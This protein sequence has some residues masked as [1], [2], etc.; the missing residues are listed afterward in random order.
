MN[1]ILQNYTQKFI[2]LD[3]EAALRTTM[4]KVREQIVDIREEHPTIPPNSKLIPSCVMLRRC[5][6]CCQSDL[7][8]C[9]PTLIYSTKVKVKYTKKFLKISLLFIQLI[10]SFF[11]CKL[12]TTYSPSKFIDRSKFVMICTATNLS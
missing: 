4:C 2:L 10:D 6:G 8:Q 7:H 9:M 11:D 12:I 1:K 5:S 3:V